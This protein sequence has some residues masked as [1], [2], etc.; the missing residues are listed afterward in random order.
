[1]GEDGD[2]KVGCG[3]GV[4]NGLELIESHEV[5]KRE[6]DRGRVFAG[7]ARQ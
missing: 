2:R 1:L 3:S 7:D 4:W 6:Q 5:G